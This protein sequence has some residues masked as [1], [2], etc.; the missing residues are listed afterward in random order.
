MPNDL[1]LLERCVIPYSP[2]WF[3]RDTHRLLTQ[4]RFGVLVFHRRAGK[5][6]LAINEL[7]KRIV[8]CPYKNPRGHYIA[9][10]YGQVK[11]IA[12]QYMKDYTID[13]PGMDH[14]NSELRAI[15]PNGAEIQLLGG[16]N[17]QS[18]RG[19][20]SDY[21]VLD[22]Y[23]QMHPGLWG[24]VFR[25]ALSDREG[26]ALFIGTPFGDNA[27]RAKW[28]QAATLEGWCRAMYKVHQTGAL[29]AKEIIAITKEITREEFEQEYLCS[30]TA[31]I[32]GSYY[33]KALELMDLERRITSVPHD[34]S[35]QVVTSWDLGIKDATVVHFWQLAGT[36]HRMIDVES[37][38][39]IGLPEIIHKISGK[40]YNYSMHIAPHDIKV[41][42]L[43]TGTSRLD[44]AASL[45]VNFDLAPM[46]GIQDGIQATRILLPQCV[47]D[48]ERCADSIS[49][50]RL[51]RTEYDDKLQRFKNN[52]LH[53]WTSDFADSVRYYA[54]TPKQ[55][56]SFALTPRDYTAED[57]TV[58]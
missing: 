15:F 56:I 14:N 4:H 39:G 47:I 28:D 27:F 35:L 38:I 20:Y 36:E 58:I 31:A 18:H 55:P 34:P 5:T 33:G 6:V 25:P 19:I 26:G 30:W 21:A 52:P 51:Y 3:Q 29:S 43:G 16:D 7:I 11:R 10:Y 13:I 17:Y 48:R 9:P 42:E 32:K 2:R 44:I 45:G 57:R 12:W 1:A 41:R 50:L 24:E 49:A 37:F 53:D 22:E 40:P 46:L 54:V 8:Q 23:A